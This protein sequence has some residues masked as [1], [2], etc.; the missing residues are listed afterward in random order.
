MLALGEHVDYWNGLGWKDR[1]SSAEFTQRQ[2]DY[3]HNMRL[4]SAYTPQMVVNGRSELVGNDASALQK[5][6]AD[7]PNLTDTVDL[8]ITPDRIAHVRIGSAP[9]GGKLLLM[10]TESNLVTHVKRGENGGKD[11][12]HAAVVRHIADLGSVHP[13][14]V[15]D[16][17][18]RLDQAWK[19]ADLKVV[20]LVQSGPGGPIVGAASARLP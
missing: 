9:A 1:F 7:S 17:P 2:T 13:N 20:A 11:L 5:A 19:T 4:D 3:V 14:T 16:A 15:I 8:K 12:V 6:L 10:I 18:L